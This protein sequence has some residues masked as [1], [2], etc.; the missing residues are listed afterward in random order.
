V[1]VGTIL[2]YLLGGLWYSPLL[3]GARWAEGVRNGAGPGSRQPVAALVLQLAGTFLLAWLIALAAARDI[4]PAALLIVLTVFT[5]LVAGAVFA[6]H[7]RA[8]VMIQGGYFLAMA[9]VMALLTRL[10]V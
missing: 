10:L 8:A 5:L 1:G 4:W 6:G 7:S 2:T 9:A 3:F